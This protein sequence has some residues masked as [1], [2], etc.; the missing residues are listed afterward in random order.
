MIIEVDANLL[1]HPLDG[2]GHQC[3]CFHTMGGGI[4]LRIKEKY[5]EAY[6]ADIK[7]GRRGDMSRLGKFSVVKTSDDKFIYNLY[8]QYN[9]GLGKRCTNYEAL[10]TALEGMAQHAIQANVLKL[11]LPKNMGCRLGGGNWNIVRALI[12]E[13]FDGDSGIELT[14]CNY[15]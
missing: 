12:G 15:D 7:H 9:F 11:G 13:V 3:N 6:Q 4:A 5:P 2:F 14:I 8:G 1:E 10:Y